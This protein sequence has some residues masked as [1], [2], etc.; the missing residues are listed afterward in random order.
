MKLKP[1]HCSLFLSSIKSGCPLILSKTNLQ[2]IR[3]VL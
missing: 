1:V 3:N 2:M